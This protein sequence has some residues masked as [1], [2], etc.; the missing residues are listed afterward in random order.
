TFPSGG[1][2]PSTLRFASTV[3]PVTVNHEV[4][5]V[6]TVPDGGL[7]RH[8]ALSLHDEP[9]R[10]PPTRGTSG[11]GYYSTIAAAS[12][13]PRGAPLGAGRS[14]FCSGMRQELNSHRMTSD[15]HSDAFPSR[16]R[17]TDA[18]YWRDLE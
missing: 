10:R 12:P 17:Q 13:R 11:P 16:L 8:A 18:E 15:A 6:P 4:L 3:N 5:R 14:V 2:P 1:A 9:R 7:R